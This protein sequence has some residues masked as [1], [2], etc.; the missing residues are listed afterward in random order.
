LDLSTLRGEDGHNRTTPHEVANI[1]DKHFDGW[2]QVLSK[3]DPAV[4]ATEE[5]QALWPELVDPPPH[6]KEQM[7]K[8]NGVLPQIH[9]DSKIPKDLQDGLHRACQQKYTPQMEEGMSAALAQAYSLEEF[10]AA[11]KHL[12]KD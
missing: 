9:P 8:P 6:I 4:L 10:T 7:D 5:D 1:I 11:I 3:L 2:F 12:S